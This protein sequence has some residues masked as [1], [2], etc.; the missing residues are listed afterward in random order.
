M[1]ISVVGMPQSG[2]TMLFN[3]ISELFNIHNVEYE[4]CLFGPKTHNRV[5]SFNDLKLRSKNNLFLVK[6]HHY[7]ADLES[8]SGFVIVSKRKIK[9][10]IASRRRRGKGLFSK[11]KRLR[12][13]HQYDEKLEPYHAFKEWCV[14]LTKDC[15]EDWLNSCS[16]EKILVF[17]YDAYIDCV[18]SKEDFIK[19]LSDLLKLNTSDQQVSKLID[20]VKIENLKNNSV[21]NQKNFFNMNRI[22]NKDNKLK[23]EDALSEEEVNY[24][25]KNYP[26]YC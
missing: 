9:D 21:A 3:I 5:L 7:Q 17:D 23:V 10:S 13:L 6:E 14:Y 24:I 15:Y 25:N 8:I 19:N 2:S 26:N 20:C 18:G 22:T 1:I 12:G 11:G 16:E 4:S